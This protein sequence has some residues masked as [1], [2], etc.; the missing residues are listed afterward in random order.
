MLMQKPF[1]RTT[2]KVIICEK[3]NE[4]HSNITLPVLRDFC[5]GERKR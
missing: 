1:E 5:E 4:K 2:Q 3:E